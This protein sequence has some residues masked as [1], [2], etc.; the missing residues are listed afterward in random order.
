M[1]RED[2]VHEK[3]FEEAPEDDTDLDKKFDKLIELNELAYNDLIFSTNTSSCVEKMA[4]GLARSAKSPESP[5][6]NCKIGW[7][8]LVNKYAPHTALPLLK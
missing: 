6:G 2:K 7:D 5:K 8:R 1:V 3:E 4:F